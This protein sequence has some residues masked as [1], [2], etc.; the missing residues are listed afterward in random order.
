M[1]C[2]TV[3][4]LAV[5]DYQ[6]K[7]AY[8]L[9]WDLGDGGSIGQRR[10][11]PP[12]VMATEGKACQPAGK[13]Q[14]CGPSIILELDRD[15]APMLHPQP[16]AI[17]VQSAAQVGKAMCGRRLVRA[18]VE[19]KTEVLPCG[20]IRSGWHDTREG[21]VEHHVLDVVRREERGC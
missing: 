18:L 19:L 14:N 2:N 6:R 8:L 15:P 13:L 21:L 4:A 16:I 3:R 1:P 10:R 20:G 17:S 12:V 7:T 5:P 11:V 9:R